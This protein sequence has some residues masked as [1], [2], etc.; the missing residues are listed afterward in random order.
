MIP[1][2]IQGIKDGEY[3]I[4]IT[5]A[6]E[7]VENMF[8]EFFGEIEIVGILRKL[9]NRYTVE[10]KARCYAN[11]VCDMT[12]TSYVESIETE[13]KCSYLANTE[14]FWQQNELEQDDDER[15]IHEDAKYIDIGNDIREQLAVNLPLKKVAPEFRDKDLEDIYPQYSKKND[16][17]ETDSR[18]EPL[19]KLKFN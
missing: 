6:V 5:V 1:I 18:W 15:V 3:D 10:L 2:Y 17:E 12:L 13:F 4:N 16:I 19:K 14:L 11:L 7:E 8:P 9:G